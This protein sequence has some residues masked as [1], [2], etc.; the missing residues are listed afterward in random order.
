MNHFVLSQI[1]ED[2]DQEKKDISFFIENKYWVLKENHTLYGRPID[3]IFSKEG[4][5]DL[6]FEIHQ[7]WFEE[8]ANQ[9]YGLESQVRSEMI[10]LL[11]EKISENHRELLKNTVS[12]ASNYCYSKISEFISSKFVRYE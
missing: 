9:F 4:I 8:P 7:G 2:L 6:F 5:L 11:D 3:P 10:S 1:F 12:F